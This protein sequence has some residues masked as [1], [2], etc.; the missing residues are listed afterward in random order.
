MSPA[1]ASQVRVNGAPKFLRVGFSTEASSLY[2]GEA[3][4]GVC[5]D[6]DG[7]FIADG[8]RTA[9]ATAKFQRDEVVAVVLNLDPTSENKNTVSLF[10][11]GVRV[12]PPQLLPESLHGKTL[13]PA[14]S[15]K[16]MSVQLNF[17]PVQ[18]RA[19][20]FNC[21]TV[22]EALE[23]HVVAKPDPAPKDGICE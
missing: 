7:A 18:L 5:F 16:C 17:G 15:F 1:Q 4:D 19:L 22:Q 21:R 12:S 14:I 6:S 3:T 11:D 13:Y 23:K 9:I 8:K 2:L 10:R 20:P